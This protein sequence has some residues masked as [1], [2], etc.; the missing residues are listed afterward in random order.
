MLKQKKSF[1]NY[2]RAAWWAT[3]FLGVVIGVVSQRI[4]EF[5]PYTDEIFNPIEKNQVVKEWMKKMGFHFSSHDDSNEP[6]VYS[7]YEQENSLPGHPVSSFIV[8]RSG[9]SLAYDARL[10]NPAWVFENLT[11]ESVRGDVDRSQFSFK[12]DEQIPQH[13]RATLASYKGQ[14]L[15]QGHMAPAADHRSHPE[16]MSDTFYLTNICPQ[17]PQFNREYWSKLEKHVRDLTKEYRNVSVITGPLYLPYQEGKRRFVKY[18]VIG[19]DDVA[20]PSHFFKVIVLEDEKGKREVR[21]YVMPN[22]VIS[23]NTPLD[24]FKSTVQKVEK[25]AGLLL[26]NS[27]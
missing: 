23:P 9:Y 17:C 5:K 14:G 12:E 3:L 6:F 2:G 10:R 16:A 4:I 20:V 8:N 13:L 27:P 15:D 24:Q 11:A 19:Q 22:R 1:L 18:Q 7:H 26:F 25:A 21:T